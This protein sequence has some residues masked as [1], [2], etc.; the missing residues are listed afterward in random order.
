VERLI[1]GRNELRLDDSGRIRAHDTGERETIE[2]GLVFRSIGYKGTGLEGV[3]FDEGRGVIPNE[4][5]RVTDPASGEAVR[6]PTRSA[7]SSVD[8][9]A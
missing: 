8:H 6:A 7:G 1:V 9:R 4:G 3:P 2:C 5:G